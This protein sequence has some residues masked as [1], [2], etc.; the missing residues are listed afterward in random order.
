M[1]KFKFTCPVCSEQFDDL[2]SYAV[3]VK[4]HVDEERKIKEELKKK[5]FIEEKE[6]DKKKVLEIKES[7]TKLLNEYLDLVTDYEKKYGESPFATYKSLFGT[8]D[9]DFSWF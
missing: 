6:A 1:D 5:K 2:E 9:F 7:A 8:S 3:H 4:G